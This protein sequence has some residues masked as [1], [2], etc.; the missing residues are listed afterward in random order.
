MSITDYVSNCY[1]P[2]WVPMWRAFQGTKIAQLP[3][4]CICRIR[5]GSLASRE[6]ITN[7]IQSLTSLRDK[8]RGIPRSQWSSRKEREGRKPNPPPKRGATL[9]QARMNA[10]IQEE[11]KWWKGKGREGIEEGQGEE[12]RKS[13]NGEEQEQIEANSIPLKHTS[14]Y[15]SF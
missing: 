5:A 7:K 11:I 8:Q 10:E 1:L 13:R 2:G 12:A 3:N 15:H 14:L 6:S 4:W 9:H